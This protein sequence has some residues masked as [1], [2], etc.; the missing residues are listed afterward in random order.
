MVSC[1]SNKNLKTSFKKKKSLRREQ[2]WA[3]ERGKE[4]RNKGEEGWRGA[5]WPPGFGSMERPYD[6]DDDGNERD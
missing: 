6:R 3:A 2:R 5:G 1:N 4:I